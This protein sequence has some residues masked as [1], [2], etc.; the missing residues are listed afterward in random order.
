MFYCCRAVPKPPNQIDVDEVTT[1]RIHLSWNNVKGK[2]NQCLRQRSPTTARGT[3]P[4]QGVS[5]LAAKTVC[6]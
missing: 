1:E 5:F 6:Q 2:R 3:N 4:A